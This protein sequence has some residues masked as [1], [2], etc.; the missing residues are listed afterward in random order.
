MFDWLGS[1]QIREHSSGR[2]V[3]AL[4]RTTRIIGWIAAIAGLALVLQVI[5]V[6]FWLASLPAMLVAF[7]ILLASLRRELTIDRASGV[8]RLD[9]RAFG[10]GTTSVV[11]LFH[12]RAVIIVARSPADGGRFVA[13]LDRRV[14]D[15]IFLDES[16]RCATLLELAEVIAEVAEVRL[17]Y[18]AAAE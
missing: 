15:A 3:L 13:Y 11:P 10:I 18:D 4:S 5:S 9:Q 17:E 2:L 6:S 1:L 7:G 12:L 14:G 8:L 16:K